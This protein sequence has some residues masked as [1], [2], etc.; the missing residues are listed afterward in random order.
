MNRPPHGTLCV[1][2]GCCSADIYDGDAPVCFA[3][4]AG[5][6][7]KSKS[8]TRPVILSERQRVEGSAVLSTD[9]R[10]RIAG[11]DLDEQKEETMSVPNKVRGY[12]PRLSEEVRAAILAADPSISHREVAR[13]LGCSDVSVLNIRKKAGIVLTGN[14]RGRKPRKNTDTS[15]RPSLGA[16][17][18]A[19]LE[20]DGN[21]RTMVT[22]QLCFTP[23][24]LNLIWARLTPDIKGV[25]IAA[26]LES[27]ASQL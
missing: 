1:D 3:C 15:S 17:S 23:E 22:I 16:P 24:Q 21:D 9:S 14:S 18:F 19:D 25:A 7:C 12:R 6:P 8:S 27:N 20:K 2:C 5:E 11:F 13:Q 10:L 4:D 26:A